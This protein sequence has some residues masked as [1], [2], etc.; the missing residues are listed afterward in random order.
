M[1]LAQDYAGD[2]LKQYGHSSYAQKYTGVHAEH[3]P[4]AEVVTLAAQPREQQS[5]ARVGGR[6][7]SPTS[8]GLGILILSQWSGVAAW[9]QSGL[10]CGGCT[11]L[12]CV[13]VA[14]RVSA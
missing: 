12:Y 2:Y 1:T 7:S 14:L 5:E 3:E 13:R 11:G 9:V 4:H 8:N 6:G 10:H